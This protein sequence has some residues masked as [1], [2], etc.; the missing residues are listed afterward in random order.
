MDAPA[1]VAALGAVVVVS[2]G[3]GIAY[4]VFRTTAER[5]RRE[6]EKDLDK[7]LIDSQAHLLAFRE[8]EVARLNNEVARLTSE[9]STY[10]T[11]EERITQRADV[12]KLRKEV[13]ELLKSHEMLLKDIIMQFRSKRGAIQ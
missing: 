6:T 10:R 7:E 4:A 1:I 12:E 8:A 2:T 11:L 3:L 5:T 9:L 13:T